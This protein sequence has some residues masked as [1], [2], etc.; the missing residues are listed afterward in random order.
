MRSSAARP[1]SPGISSI[2]PTQGEC[3]TGGWNPKFWSQNPPAALL[4]E[5]AKKEAMFNLL[6][7]KSLPIVKIQK[8]ELRPVKK[9]KDAFEVVARSST[10]DISP[11][12]S[13]WP[14]GS[15]SSGR[16]I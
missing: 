3:E 6:L 11:P 2:H 10:Q 1:S 12:P 16:T 14:T 7:Y 9:E 5:W 4:E 8:A 13:R 15:R